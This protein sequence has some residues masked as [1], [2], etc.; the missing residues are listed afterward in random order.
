MANL[1]EYEY[2]NVFSHYFSLK[3]NWALLAETFTETK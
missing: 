2:N 1:I 3:N